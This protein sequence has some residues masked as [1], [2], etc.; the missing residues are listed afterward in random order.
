MVNEN[1]I[2]ELESN[3]RDKQV[4]LCAKWAPREGRHFGCYGLGMQWLIR[5]RGSFG[6]VHWLNRR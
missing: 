5:Q 3:L 2:A 4:G 1:L 6:A